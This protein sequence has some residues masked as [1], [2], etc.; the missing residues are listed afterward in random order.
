MEQNKN[1]PRII[2]IVVAFFCVNLAAA[3]VSSINQ[4]ISEIKST[5]AQ[6][7]SLA[8][9]KDVFKAVELLNETRRE[10]D[11]YIGYYL[12]DEMRKAKAEDANYSPYL[13]V[14]FSEVLTASYWENRVQQAQK[15]IN[16]A[17]KAFSEGH[18]QRTL[19]SQDEVWSYLKA[20][21]GV[22]SMIKDVYYLDKNLERIKEYCQKDV[23]VLASIFLRMNNFPVLI[24]EEVKIV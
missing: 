5:E 15:S 12:E 19:D 11:S 22:G 13:N 10:F 20:V 24:E 17:K 23:T 21:Y 8:S 14:K 18:H 9:K 16:L 7:N 2:L 1:Y 4:Y 3:Q 6:G